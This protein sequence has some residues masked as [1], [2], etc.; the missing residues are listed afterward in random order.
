MRK[1]YSDLCSSCFSS[2]KDLFFMIFFNIFT[3]TYTENLI[4]NFISEES[5][6]STGTSYTYSHIIRAVLDYR[7][8]QNEIS[9]NTKNNDLVFLLLLLFKTVHSTHQFSQQ[10]AYH[11]TSIWHF[12][13]STACNVH[14]NIVMMKY[15]K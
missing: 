3:R 13:T 2:F 10:R 1:Y 12:I 11:T 14:G 5:V 7:F 9:T 8:N 15:N 4:F 6:V